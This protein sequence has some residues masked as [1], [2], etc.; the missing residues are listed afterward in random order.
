MRHRQDGAISPKQ[1]QPEGADAESGRVRQQQS[2]LQ[3]CI[4]VTHQAPA[5]SP[6]FAVGVRTQQDRAS[7]LIPA[8]RR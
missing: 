5:M 7:V 2:E 3:A 6:L 1:V 4:K 8:V